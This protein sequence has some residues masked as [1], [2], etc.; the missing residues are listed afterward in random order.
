MREIQVNNHYL[1]NRLGD[2]EI[3]ISLEKCAISAILDINDMTR[4]R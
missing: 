4:I 1:G 3:K 2:D